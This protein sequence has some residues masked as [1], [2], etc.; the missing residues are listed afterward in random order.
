MTDKQE[1]TSSMSEKKNV[2]EKVSKADFIRNW[3]KA[4]KD[5][6]PKWM[7]KLFGDLESNGYKIAKHDSIYVYS[8]KSQL[9]KLSKTNKKVK[10]VPNNIT[11]K[12]NKIKTS[13]KQAT[14]NN[15]KFYRVAGL[16][17]S[18][19][20]WLQEKSYDMHDLQEAIKLLDY[21]EPK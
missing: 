8:I 10:D 7:N 6:S 12:V 9:E 1:R 19:K 21:L 5:F 14:D 3:L 16:A 20:S 17:W 15:D 4:N 18:L 2:V 13:P 11:Q